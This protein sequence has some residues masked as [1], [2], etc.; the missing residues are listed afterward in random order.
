[1]APGT[2][3][4]GRGGAHISRSCVKKNRGGEMMEVF[5]AKNRMD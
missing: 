2:Q 1:M 5:R 4:E 3:E